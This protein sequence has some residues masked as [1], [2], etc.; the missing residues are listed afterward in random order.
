MYV[1]ILHRH[2]ILLKLNLKMHTHIHENEL[3]NLI[4]KVKKCVYM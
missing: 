2:Q 1:C 3:P 4:S